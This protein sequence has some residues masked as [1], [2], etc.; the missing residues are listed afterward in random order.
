[1]SEIENFKIEN[2]TK[3]YDDLVDSFEIYLTEKMPVFDWN[4]VSEIPF[5]SNKFIIEHADNLNII[6][7]MKRTNHLPIEVLKKKFNSLPSEKFRYLIIPNEII[8]NYNLDEN[9]IKN[10][11]LY[12]PITD[13]FLELKHNIL[14]KKMK[15]IILQKYLQLN[16]KYLNQ[17]K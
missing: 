16:K 7:I 5:L 9:D 12:H 3:V 17:K 14:N 15:D 13:E 4:V 10:L 11:S 6:E 2:Q 8:L 1:M